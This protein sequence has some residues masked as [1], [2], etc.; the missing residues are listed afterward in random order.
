MTL[1]NAEY[2]DNTE[3]PDYGQGYADGKDK[4]HMEVRTIAVR[5]TLGTVVVSRASLRGPS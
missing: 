2:T 4:A 5:A 1:S 3:S